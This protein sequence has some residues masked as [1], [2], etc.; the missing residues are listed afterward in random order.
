[1]IHHWKSFDWEITDFTY[2]RSSTPSG[3]IIPSQTSKP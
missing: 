3:E 2:Q 1:M